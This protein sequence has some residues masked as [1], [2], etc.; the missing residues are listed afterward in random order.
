[1]RAMEQGMRFI[2]QDKLYDDYGNHLGY[3]YRII[4]VL[5]TE[6]ETI[7]K[8][9]VEY[10]TDLYGIIERE[11]NYELKYKEDLEHENN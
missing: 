9:V 2:E 6:N 4:Q 10:T 7:E 3:V 11:S 1:M 5:K 8:I